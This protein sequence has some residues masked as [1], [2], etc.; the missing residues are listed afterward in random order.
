MVI[1]MTRFLIRIVSL[2][3]CLLS[4]TSM[5]EEILCPPGVTCEFSLEKKIN[6]S[7]KESNLTLIGSFELPTKKHKLEKYSE[8]EYFKYVTFVVD[9]SYK[10][11]L[12]EKRIN[13][14]IPVYALAKVAQKKSSIADKNDIGLLAKEIHQ[15]ER[16]LE[17]GHLDRNTYKNKIKSLRMKIL[18]SPGYSMDT[19]VLVPVKR[20]GLDY[21]YRGIDVPIKFGERYILFVFRDISKQGS[22]PLFPWDIDLYKPEQALPVIQ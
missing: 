19:M 14:K 2:C 4:A 18:N 22:T 1:S 7:L 9:K 10:G 15:L 5:A 8:N 12:G 17:A 3:I 20:G 16:D 6:T 21:H 11:D 13:L